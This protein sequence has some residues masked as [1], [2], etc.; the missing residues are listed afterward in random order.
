MA[1]HEM[2]FAR[3]AADL[4]VFLKGGV[5]VEKGPPEQV[6]DD[7]VHPDTREFLARVHGVG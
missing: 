4:V 1:T 5:L 2:S 6:F 7:P 3:R